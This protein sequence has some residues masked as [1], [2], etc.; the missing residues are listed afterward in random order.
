MDYERELELMNRENEK[1]SKNGGY[2]SAEE[3]ERELIES[4]DITQEE[5]EKAKGDDELPEEL[6]HIIV[7]MLEK[8]L[9]G[10]RKDRDMKI[11]IEK[12]LIKQ[13]WYFGDKKQIAEFASD[14]DIAEE[15][16]EMFSI[17]LDK[18]NGILF[19]D[20]KAVKRA[21][22]AFYKNIKSMVDNQR[23]DDYTNHRYLMELD[24]LRFYLFEIET[25][26]LKRG[27]TVTTM[28]DESEVAV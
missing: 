25:E 6:F 20:E 3:L 19:G 12:V 18:E 13:G 16:P 10:Y 11:R 22:K 5:V 4:G 21:I 7:D 8:I 9:N 2:S 23:P 28:W 24:A 1:W 15:Y 14:Y 27:G 17:S 26:Y